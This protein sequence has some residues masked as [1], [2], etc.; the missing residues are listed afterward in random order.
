[1]DDPRQNPT[2]STAVIKVVIVDDDMY[3]RTALAK[4]LDAYPDLH[5]TNTYQHGAEALEAAR[6]DPPDVMLVDVAMPGMSGA[7]LTALIRE[8]VPSVRVLALTSLT[9]QETVSDMHCAGALGFLY[10]DTS[11]DAVADAI[12]AA[13]SGLSVLTPKVR[14]RLTA[15]LRPE[16]APRLTETESR[17]LKLLAE[18]LT[19]K[20]IAEQVYLSEATVKYH[21]G[22]LTKKLDATNRVTLALRAGELHLL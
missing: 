5:I 3:V 20:R 22:I 13:R 2:G 4:L 12:R 6:A 14:D 16:D 7:E 17:I 11:H 10:K 15:P 9:S 19:N 8:Q 18:G 1:M 21:I